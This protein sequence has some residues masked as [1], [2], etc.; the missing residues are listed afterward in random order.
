MI[1][2]RR[3]CADINL[4]SARSCGKRPGRHRPSSRLVCSQCTDENDRKTVWLT[5]SDRNWEGAS[6]ERLACERQCFKIRRMPASFCYRAC[7]GTT[8][9]QSSALA[10]RTAKGHTVN[11][12]PPSPST[13]LIRQH[14]QQGAMPNADASAC[15]R[16]TPLCLSTS[17]GSV[18][19]DRAGAQFY[20]AV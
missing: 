12:D 6:I 15:D 18:F 20:P 13:A 9:P 7:T 11:G 10:A 17:A 3:N 16:P 2:L 1:Y 4:F 19:A 14:Q 8:V 5:P